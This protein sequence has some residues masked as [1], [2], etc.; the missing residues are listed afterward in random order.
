MTGV[1]LLALFTGL[2]VNG[3]YFDANGNR[4]K[5]KLFSSEPE[6]TSNMPVISIHFSA[7]KKLLPAMIMMAP[8]RLSANGR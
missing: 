7:G 3:F 1:L 2:V 8:A 5:E 4:A 6:I